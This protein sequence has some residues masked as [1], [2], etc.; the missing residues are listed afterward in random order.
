VIL[1]VATQPQ[2]VGRV[3]NGTRIGLTWYREMNF[4]YGR[5]VVRNDDIELDL[6]I[7]LKYLQGVGI[8]DI[9]AEDDQLTGFSSLS[10]DFQIDYQKGEWMP[11][12]RL[13]GG[14]IAFPKTVGQGFGVDL[15]LAMLV[16]KT[17][18]FGAAVTDLGAIHWKG[19]VYEASDGSLVDLAASGLENFNIINGLEDFATNSGVLEWQRAQDRRIPLASTARIGFG[20]L[21]GDRA[22]VGVDV[23]LP[24]NDEAGNLES[25]VVG[26]GGDLRPL[27]WLQLSASLMAGGG[28][29][30]KVPAGITFIVGKGTW[31]AG[32][33]SRDLITFFTQGNPTLSLSM[34]FLR[35]R[36]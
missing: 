20:K 18:K 5:H 11:G 22:E 35:F 32:F 15:G 2:L 6:G 33:A 3:V 7:G 36:L 25:P 23:V 17:W 29:S 16:H 4:S 21:L 12:A 31:E 9:R 14:M 13:T 1:G 19:N 24:L 8:L 27:R 30:V 10:P 28:M 34:G 26:A